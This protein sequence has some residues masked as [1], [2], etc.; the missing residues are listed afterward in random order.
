MLETMKTA[1][2]FQK[3]VT[4]NPASMPLGELMDAATINGA[5]ALGLDTGEIREGAIADLSI[6]DTDNSYFISPGSFLANLVYTA[7]SDVISSVIAQGR[8]IM[9]NRVVEGE[10]EILTEARKVLNQI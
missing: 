2:L 7:H 3:A 4:G 5:R 9:R 8:F 6:V 10:E 1:A